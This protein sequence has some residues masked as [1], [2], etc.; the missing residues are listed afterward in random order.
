MAGEHEE[1]GDLGRSHLQE[2]AEVREAEAEEAAEDSDG[3]GDG[4]GDGG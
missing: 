3:G 4:G 2:E 1:G